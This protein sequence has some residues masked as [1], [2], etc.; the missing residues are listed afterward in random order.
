MW[1]PVKS[2]PIQPV[3]G[4]IRRVAGRTALEAE[5]LAEVYR[6]A[7]GKAIVDKIVDLIRKKAGGMQ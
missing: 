6:K 4:E 7:G 5:K 1:P 3:P 2:R